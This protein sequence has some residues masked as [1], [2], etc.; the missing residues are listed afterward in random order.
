MNK[1]NVVFEGASGI[2][3]TTLCKKFKD[4]YD[5]IPE[6]NQLFEKIDSSDNH[7]YL[8]KQ[9]ERF[10]IG[11]KSK[12]TSIF[13]GDFFQPIW[14]NW[15]YN[16]PKEFLSAKDTLLF[17][18]KRIRTQEIL[19]PDL[20]IVFFCSEQELRKRKNFD[21]NRKR[22]N[23]EKHLLFI[24]PQISFFKYLQEFTNINVKFIEYLDL[25]NTIKKVDLAIKDTEIKKKND[26]EEFQ[27]IKIWIKKTTHNTVYN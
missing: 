20:Y 18:E 26:L 25:E 5:I 2:G 9:I 17:Y 11:N 3:K 4:V 7:W 22:R 13:D 27:K 12:K 14:Y 8:K 23:F 24:K 19:F 21:K 10:G 16:Y 6:V 15:V 1:L